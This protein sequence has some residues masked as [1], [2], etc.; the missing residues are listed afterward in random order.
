MATR[1]EITLA[2]FAFNFG[3][4]YDEAVVLPAVVEKVAAIGNLKKQDLA[5]EIAFDP[6]TE[7]A[8]AVGQACRDVVKAIA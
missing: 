1:Y 5:K 8:N 4:S 3:L 7:L 2:N 6:T